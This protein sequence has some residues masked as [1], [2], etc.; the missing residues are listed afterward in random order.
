M[1]QR[2]EVERWVRARAGGMV[3][4]RTSKGVF[5]ETDAPRSASNRWMVIGELDHRAIQRC[6]GGKPPVWGSYSF[7]VNK[8]LR[9]MTAFPPKIA[10]R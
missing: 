2:Y 6:T 9:L 8:L 5:R 10:W 7:C 1:E 4:S 3:I